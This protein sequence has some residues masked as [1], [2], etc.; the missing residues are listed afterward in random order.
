MLVQEYLKNN[1][2]LRSKDKDKNDMM[3]QDIYSCICQK[4]WRYII[5]YVK[6]T[7]LSKFYRIIRSEWAYM[8][9]NLILWNKS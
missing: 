9:R 2:C 4:K 3:Y 7:A 1:E 8:V 6:P 5:Q